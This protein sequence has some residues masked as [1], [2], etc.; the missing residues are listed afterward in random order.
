VAQMSARFCRHCGSSVSA[1]ASFCARCG[2][3]LAETPKIDTSKEKNL[4]FDRSGS[5]QRGASNVP[6]WNTYYP[7]L[8][9]ADVEQRQF[10]TFWKSNLE[11]GIALDIKANLSYL[12]VY[13]YDAIYRFIENNDINQ[14]VA[15]FELLKQGYGNYDKISYLD[16][17]LA[18]AWLF[19][20]NYD[21]AWQMLRQ[22]SKLGFEDILNIRARCSDTAIDGNDLLSVLGSGLT[23]FGRAHREEIANLATTLLADFHQKHGMNFVEHFCKQFN[24]ASLTERDIDKLEAFFPKEKEFTDLKWEWQFE[25]HHPKP[26]RNETYLFSA[27]PFSTSRLLVEVD[28]KT[29]EVAFSRDEHIQQPRIPF[30]ELPRIVERALRYELKKVLAE[31]EN[32]VKNAIKKAD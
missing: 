22:A 21:A 12:F 27:V 11:K 8:S 31:C 9:D 3:S 6:E 23:K 25:Q 15:R 26:K 14:L 24:Y 10:Y 16:G 30:E 4:K 18:D 29:L 19:L 20:G 5:P 1:E 7:N 13:A 28:P 2:N 32:T 17:W